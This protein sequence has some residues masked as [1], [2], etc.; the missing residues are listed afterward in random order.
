M[1]LSLSVLFIWVS[2]HI[3]F[4]LGMFG[5]K[6]LLY[7]WPWLN[8]GEQLWAQWLVEGQFSTSQRREMGYSF[9]FTFTN[10]ILGFKPTTFHYSLRQYAM[11]LFKTKSYYL[12]SL[13]RKIKLYNCISPILIVNYW[14][15]SFKIIVLDHY[16]YKTDTTQTPR[17]QK[18]WQKKQK[19][20]RW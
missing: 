11:M 8:P 1:R 7:C 14:G 19:K 13:S 15:F 6:V 20:R 9:P 10:T 5:G 16:Q 17:L 4:V 18:Y 2:Y 3:E 12:L